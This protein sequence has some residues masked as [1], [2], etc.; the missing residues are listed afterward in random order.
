MLMVLHEHAF[1]SPP[2]A[3]TTTSIPCSWRT[4][5]MA[6]ERAHYHT[7]STVHTYQNRFKSFPVKMMNMPMPCC[8]TWSETHWRQPDE[9]RLGAM[10]AAFWAGMDGVLELRQTVACHSEHRRCFNSIGVVEVPPMPAQNAAGM[11]PVRE[12]QPEYA[13]SLPPTS[14]VI[15][16]THPRNRS[17]KSGC[18]RGQRTT[19]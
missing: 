3:T 7:G 4:M 13:P 11:A 10:P 19:H 18:S 6:P 15:L 8:A 2:L 14:P 1:E 17:K 16:E 9:A 5:S 12:L